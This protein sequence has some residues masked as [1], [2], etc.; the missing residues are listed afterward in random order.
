MGMTASEAGE[1]SLN[2]FDTFLGRVPLFINI[3]HFCTSMFWPRPNQ[4]MEKYHEKVSARA[5]L[6]WRD[7]GSTATLGKTCLHVFLAVFP[8]P[9]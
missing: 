5:L 3:A 2:S 8:H 4:E 9:S 1:N 7:T 6:A